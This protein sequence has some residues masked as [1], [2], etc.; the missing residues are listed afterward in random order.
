VLWIEVKSRKNAGQK[1]F[2]RVGLA[3][4]VG[5]FLRGKALTKLAMSKKALRYVE[6]MGDGFKEVCQ[7]LGKQIDLFE[8]LVTSSHGELS[9][10]QDLALVWG[11]FVRG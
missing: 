7:E 3:G 10:G 1:F 9:S 5:D 4:C 8:T 6:A 11:R 2:G